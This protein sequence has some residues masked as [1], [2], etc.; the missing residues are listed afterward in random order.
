MDLPTAWNLDDKSYNLSIDS[1]GLRVNY[2]GFREGYG[3]FGAIRANHP[4]PSQCNLFYFEVDIIDEGKNKGIGI[5]FCEKEDGTMVPGVIKEIMAKYIGRETTI[6]MD[7]C[8]LLAI[9]LDVV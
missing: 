7:R 6:T 9:P 5:G 1:S 3:K 2:E 4:I 8:F